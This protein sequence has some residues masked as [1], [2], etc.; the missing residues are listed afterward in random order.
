[1]RYR[2]PPREGFRPQRPPPRI[3]LAPW[4]YVIV[5]VVIA[6]AAQHF[7]RPPQKG[8]TR[9]G[10]DIVAPANTE[11]VADGD[12]IDIGRLRMRLF[13]I[14]APELAQRCLDAIGQ[15]YNCGETAARAL[16]DLVRN[17]PLRC[18]SHGIDQFGRT[19]AVCTAGDVELNAA[20]VEA[21]NAVAYREGTLAYVPAE[22]R[23]KGAK[24]GLWAGRFELP[25]DFR[26]EA[27]RRSE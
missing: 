15:P 7:S 11:R 16:Q 20:M 2:R 21:G 17:K 27:G 12:S 5:L 1:V 14:D 25:K 10:E 24:R 13:G 19:L 22:N 3:P 4:F 6:A 8:I 23:A 18:V 26:R 9:E